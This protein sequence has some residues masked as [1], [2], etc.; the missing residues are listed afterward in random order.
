[1][2]GSITEDFDLGYLAPT[3]AF[4]G[5]FNLLIALLNL[6]PGPG[7]DGQTAWRA[8][9][10]MFGWLRARRSAHQALPASKRKRQPRWVQKNR[11]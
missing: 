3:I 1:V 7:M 10:L 11:R 4:L 8:F 5:Y 6:A 9:P 2:I